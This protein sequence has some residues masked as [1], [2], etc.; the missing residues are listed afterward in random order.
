VRSRP[1][2][3]LKRV[4]G[5]L[6]TNSRCHRAIHGVQALPKRLSAA[7]RARSYADA[8]LEHDGGA[9]DRRARRR[10]DERQYPRFADRR[11]WNTDP[12]PRDRRADSHRHRAPCCGRRN[13]KVNLDDLRWDRPDLDCEPQQ[14]RAIPRNLQLDETM[15]RVRV[16]CPGEGCTVRV[17]V[18]P[19]VAL[20]TL[21]T[22]IPAT[23][24]HGRK[25]VGGHAARR[26]R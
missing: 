2:K 24:G 11:N 7:A 18:A 10:S 3:P 22:C 14:A 15:M 1:P 4:N 20:S 23:I 19:E 6:K 13:C 21:P 26:C 9:D 17:K 5:L 12:T 8:D 16:S 25:F